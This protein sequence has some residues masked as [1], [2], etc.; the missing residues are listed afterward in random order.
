MD[1]YTDFDAIGLAALVSTGQVSPSELLDTAIER[2]ETLNPELN[3]V[4]T[5]LFDAARAKHCRWFA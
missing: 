2:I 3:A 4:V 5:P 1:S